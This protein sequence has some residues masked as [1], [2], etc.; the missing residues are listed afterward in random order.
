MTRQ[1]RSADQPCRRQKT[2]PPQPPLR[3]VDSVK[4]GE[5]IYYCVIQAPVATSN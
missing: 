5:R 3:I 4:V 1:Q 2:A